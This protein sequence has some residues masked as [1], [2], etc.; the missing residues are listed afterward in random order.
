MGVVSMQKNLD[1]LKA[2]RERL[3]SDGKLN[4][5]SAALFDAM[6]SMLELVVMLFAEKNTPKTARNSGLPSSR[7][8]KDDTARSAKG[9]KGRGPKHDHSENDNMRMEETF[10]TSEVRHCDGCGHD[11][12]E[13]RVTDHEQRRLFDIVFVTTVHQ[14]SAEIKRCPVCERENRGVFPDSMPGPLQY[15][16]GL[17]AFAVNLLISQMVAV[18][19]ATELIRSISGRLISE[20]TLLAWVMRL[21]QALAQWERVA[22]D[23]L[24]HSPV[25]HA[26]ETSIRID[27]KNHWIHSCSSG[28]VVVKLCHRKRGIE[29]MD[30]IG[31]LPRYGA[32]RSRD[33]D[34]DDDDTKPVLVHDRWAAYFHY[35]DCDHALC[36]SHLLRD[37]DFI[38]QAH[39]HRWAGQMAKLLRT[40]SGEVAKTD[41]GALTEQRFR[42][43]RRQYRRILT[44]GR[45]E[46]PALPERKGSRGRAPKTDAHNLHQAFLD[47][48]TEIL[49]FTRNPDCPFT[50]NTA[51][52]SVRM[53]KVKQKV[54]GCFRSVQF[55]EAYCR[56]SSYLQTMNNL[57]YNP[58]TAI[59]IALNNQAAD[60]LINS[61]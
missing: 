35:E 51:E 39:G 4:E 24:L 14:V 13:V 40:T 36:G 10:E 49:R 16:P 27:R 60:I 47:Y 37:L 29:A 53:S 8:P 42:A 1:E 54:S 7:S 23:R 12:T 57:G 30:A 38:V 56:I 11:L 25:M 59:Q 20:A 28:D 6:L 61:R 22:V 19:R 48:E 45:K 3:L 58:M 15:G 18:R 26:D 55:A 17:R 5:E 34:D 50:N 9:S 43:V 2:R 33:A 44:Q 41:A 46:L 21:H 32:G 52:R 31:I